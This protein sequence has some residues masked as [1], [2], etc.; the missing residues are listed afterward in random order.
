MIAFVDDLPLVEFS[1]GSVFAFREEWLRGNLLQAAAQAGYQ[2]WWL[3]D[4]VTQSVTYY[5]SSQFSAPVVG[6]N[7]LSETVQSVLQAIGY[8]EVG[9]HFRASRPARPISLL[10]MAHRAEGYELAFFEMLRLAV[11][12]ELNDGATA[13]DLLDSSRCVKFLIGAKHFTQDCDR[14]RDEII[15]FTRDCLLA[16][17]KG[18]NV[19][20]LIR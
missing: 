10:E 1:G 12:M 2:N 3:A 20:V 19:S 7:R 18:G 5:L 11:R 4:H 6:V 13:L 16:N 9:E 17:D 15:S 8:A 14:L